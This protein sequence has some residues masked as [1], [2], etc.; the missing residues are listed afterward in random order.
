MIEKD[1]RLLFFGIMLF[2]S[3]SLVLSLGVMSGQLRCW[4]FE[5]YIFDKDAST[6]TLKKRGI[7]VNEVAERSLSE[8]S[9]V[10][11]E[12]IYD[13]NSMLYKVCLLMDEG[14]RLSLGG[15]SNQKEQQK[16]VDWIRSYLDGRSPQSITSDK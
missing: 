13:E 10:K 8:I 15:S 12:T 3:L 5:T 16:I 14:D 11:L 6:L 7:W 9:Q 4:I 1:N 2:L